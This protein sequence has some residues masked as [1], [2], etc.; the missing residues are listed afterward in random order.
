MQPDQPHNSWENEP[1]KTESDKITEM[2]APEPTPDET[3]ADDSVY[4]RKH[5]ADE[6]DPIHWS[7]NEYIDNE[8]NG[9]WFVFFAV[10]VLALIASDIF[11][12]KSYTFSIL[13]V[14]MAISV[15]IMSRRPPRS[16]EYTLSG[17]QGLYIGERLY[18]FSEFRAFGLIEDRGQHL[19]MLIPIKR[20]SPSVTFYFST[21]VGEKIVDILGARLPMESRKLDVID[22]IVRK[23]RL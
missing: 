21:D 8:K 14:V 11:L 20:F 7:A 18:H 1:D 9:A 19:I 17:N 22:I 10:I 16:I 4:T 12:I 23:L 3:P 13:V 5:I 2:Y 15:I 6:N